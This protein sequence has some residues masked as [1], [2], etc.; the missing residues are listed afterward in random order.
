MQHIMDMLPMVDQIMVLRVPGHKLYK[1][2]EN[3]ISSYPE[4]QG[5]FPS[6]SGIEMVFDA[7]KPIGARINKEDIK[8]QGEVLDF[9]RNYTV[10]T[11]NFLARGKDG[12]TDFLN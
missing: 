6:I 8:I 10:S 12:Y 11:K 3:S 7:R 1:L 2:L 5:K 9:D 4:Y